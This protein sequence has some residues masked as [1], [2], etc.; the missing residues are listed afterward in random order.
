M[1]FFLVFCFAQTSTR[2]S[3][4]PD[5]TCCS[6]KATWAGASMPAARCPPSS[7][8]PTKTRVGDAV[9]RGD[10]LPVTGRHVTG[11]RVVCLN[12]S[13]KRL[14]AV[15]FQ[16]ASRPTPPSAQ[17]R[18]TNFAAARTA[19]MSTR[20]PCTFSTVSFS[21][22]TPVVRVSVRNDRGFRYRDM[23]IAYIGENRARCRT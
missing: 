19:N 20:P 13:V 11:T 6:K 22:Y 15:C 5:K 18:W 21:P 8:S 17:R 16:T 14:T 7:K 2:K 12:G 9:T 3:P 4:R 23:L 1:S 10:R